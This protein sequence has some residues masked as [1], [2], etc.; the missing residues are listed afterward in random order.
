LV[1]QTER[2]GVLLYEP[3]Y[4][5]GSDCEAAYLDEAPLDSQG[6]VVRLGQPSGRPLPQA[7]R[8][9][10]PI[11]VRQRGWVPDNPV[12][13]IVEQ[14]K[15]TP[16]G[17]PKQWGTYVFPQKLGS[18]TLDIKDGFAEHE[19]RPLDGPGVLMFR[20]V[21]PGQWQQEIDGGNLA[22]LAFQEDFTFLR[23][24]PYDKAA[25]AIA[26]SKEPIDYATIYQHVLRYY[27]LILPAMAKRLEMTANAEDLWMS[28][29]AARYLLRT[30]S[31]DLWNHWAYMPRTR[32]LS[33]TRRELLR[34]FCCQII[35]AAEAA[36]GG[37]D[38]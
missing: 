3:E 26:A 22:K 28:P 10:V 37:V 7:K 24:L 33:E 18:D 15:F 35:E 21:V 17:D 4:T 38:G 9:A 16:S 25:A 23:I 29:T 12:R 2:Y 13:L 20:Y 14:W 8:G 27:A 11:Y 19:L 32:D 36:G 31:L 1:L 30:T 6:R 34:R 5:I